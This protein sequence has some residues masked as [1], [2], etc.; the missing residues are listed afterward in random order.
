MAIVQKRTCSHELFN[1]G[2]FSSSDSI[3]T[4]GRTDRLKRG[5]ENGASL[6][7]KMGVLQAALLLSNM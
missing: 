3:L 2:V 4:S 6:N 5:F 1:L 7:V